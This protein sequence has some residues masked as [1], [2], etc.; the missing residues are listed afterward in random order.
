[1]RQSS[2]WEQDPGIVVLCV[3]VLAFVIT[4]LLLGG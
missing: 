4:C 3:S 1:M 2:P